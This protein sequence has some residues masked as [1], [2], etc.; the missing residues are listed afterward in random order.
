M[1]RLKASMSLILGL[2]AAHVVGEDHSEIAELLASALVAITLE[3]SAPQTTR[4]EDNGNPEPRWPSLS[5]DTVGRHVAAS[6][7]LHDDSFRAR[8][9]AGID[10]QAICSGGHLH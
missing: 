9:D 7:P 6:K 1:V 4:R 3:H 5:R 2:V 8:A 10:Q